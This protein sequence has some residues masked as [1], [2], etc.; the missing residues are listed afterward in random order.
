MHRPRL[1]TDRF[2]L[3]GN[4]RFLSHTHTSTQ[5]ASSLTIVCVP[6]SPTTRSTVTPVLWIYEHYHHHLPVLAFA[7]FSFT[8]TTTTAR[9]R[10]TFSRDLSHGLHPLLCYSSARREIVLVIGFVPFYRRLSHKDGHSRF[11]PTILRVL[12]DLSR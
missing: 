11:Y 2:F 7:H 5:P 10:F 1:V 8:P 4:L 6:S 12:L 3:F 9:F